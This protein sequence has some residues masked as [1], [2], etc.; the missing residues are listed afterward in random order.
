MVSVYLSCS[1]VLMTTFFRKRERECK[2]RLVSLS[3]V[4]ERVGVRAKRA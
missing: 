1:H 4:R 2:R 3:R